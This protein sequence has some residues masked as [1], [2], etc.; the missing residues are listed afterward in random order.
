MVDGELSVQDALIRSLDTTGTVDMRL[1]TRLS[2]QSADDVRAALVGVIY[3]TLDLTTEGYET[4]DAFLSGNV[5]VKLRQAQALA[6]L[7][8]AFAAHVAAL[9]TVQ[10]ALLGPEAIIVRLGAVWVPADDI[11]A[12]V[13]HLI[14]SYRGKVTFRDLDASWHVQSTD[15]ARNAVANTATWGTPRMDALDLVE[16]LLN[17]RPIIVR[18]TIENLDGSTSTVINDT[19]TAAAQEKADAVRGAFTQWIWSDTG[20]T[21]RLVTIY[22]E[23][24]NALHPR[25]Y[26][27]S[28]LSLPGLN[29]AVLRDGDLSE[30]QKAAVWQGLQQPATLLAHAVGAGKTYTMI[31][32]A[33]EARR[34]GLAAKP[35]MLVPN[36]LVGQ[37]ARAAQQLFPGLAV[38]ALGEQD[39]ARDR[40]GVALSRIATGDWDLV[41]VPFS[42]FQFLPVDAEVLDTFYDGERQRLREALEAAQDAARTAT[43]TRAARSGVKRIEKAIERLEVRLKNTLNRIARDSAFTI[44]W[45][46][47]GIDL[48]MVDEAHNFKNLYVPSRLTVAGAPQAD[49]LRALDLRIK[50]WDMLR[51]GQKVIFATATPIMNTLGEAYVMQL[52]LQEAELAAAGI[53]TFDAWVSVFA[54]VREMCELKPDGSGFQVKSRLNTFINLPELAQ[55]W[56]TVLNVR[57]AEQL[58]LSR[59]DLVGDKPV[60]AAVPSSPALEQLTRQFVERVERIKLRQVDPSKDNMLKLTSDARLAA[61]DP[62]LLIGGE[63]APNSKL[64]ALADRVAHLYHTYDAARGTQIVFCDLATPKGKNTTDAPAADEAAPPTDDTTAAE[65]TLAGGVYHAIR[66]KLV[67]R[68]IP[69]AQ[70]AFIHDYHTNA[71]RDALFAAMNAGTVRVLIGSTA[72]M[73]T[74]MNVQQRLIALHQLDAPWRPGDVEQRDGRIL[75]QGNMW[76]Q[77]YVL[78]Y[79][80]EESF[81]SYLW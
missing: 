65:Q 79:V 57:T 19:E 2:G 32:I 8:P 60:I 47:L 29:T 26:D 81:D 49:S 25:V 6:A 61:L 27:G 77:A 80:T 38:L 67:A 37:T 4:A 12:F 48:L 10:P 16:S 52:Y 5:R 18:D 23:R 72:K 58:A 63:E 66:A 53:D 74:G 3:R 54:E 43:D 9:Q 64:K 59:P 73:G 45:R 20:R 46:E 22:N 71:A 76:P 68:G 1:I 51:Q 15:T 31:T 11:T 69:A 34:M 50:T 14:P 17:S 62:R 39:F 40:R 13:Q 55:L 70:V 78:H 33:R 24:F 36:H 28:H 41:I 30:W 7:N 44:T 35:C 42:S 75:R 21:Q 56:S